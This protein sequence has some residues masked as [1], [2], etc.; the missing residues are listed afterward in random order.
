MAYYP[1]K[2]HVYFRCSGGLFLGP[3]LFPGVYHKVGK[4]FL[5]LLFNDVGPACMRL[6]D[7][8]DVARRGAASSEAVA[9]Y[10]T[11]TY[12]RT[13]LHPLNGPHENEAAPRWRDRVTA[14]VGSRRDRQEMVV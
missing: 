8:H 5:L 10:N 3:D 7:T 11:F 1:L 4:P 12:P 9:L 14:G 13:T 2:P 6:M